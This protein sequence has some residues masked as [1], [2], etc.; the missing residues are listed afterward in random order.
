MTD[1]RRI[2]V[3][4]PADVVAAIEK[5]TNDVPQFVAET[6]ADRVRTET[7]ASRVRRQ[8]LREELDRYEEEHGA[9]TEEELDAARTRIHQALTGD[10]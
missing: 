1:M 2:S 8:L 10:P 9:F 4:L 7:D 5:L 3:L 6:V